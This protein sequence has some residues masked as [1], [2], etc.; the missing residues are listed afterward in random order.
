MSLTNKHRWKPWEETVLKDILYNADKWELKKV[1][2]RIAPTF[3]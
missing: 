3:G 2:K 1:L